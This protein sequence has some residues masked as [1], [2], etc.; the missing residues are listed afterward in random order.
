[1]K[2]KKGKVDK[3][4]ERRKNV[5]GKRVSMRMMM[6]GVKGESMR[7]RDQRSRCAANEQAT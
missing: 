5:P 4:K 3:G 6:L 1:M 7:G 2:K